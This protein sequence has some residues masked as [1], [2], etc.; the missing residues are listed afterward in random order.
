MKKTGL[1][2]LL[3]ALLVAQVFLSGCVSAF[4]TV[5]FSV[6][7]DD[8]PNVTNKD[9]KYF[10][11]RIDEQRIAS[12]DMGQT[13]PNLETVRE[14]LH[15]RHADW[16]SAEP[17]AVP[18]VVKCRTSISK[19]MNAFENISLALWYPIHLCSLGLVPIVIPA[20]KM[21]FETSFKTGPEATTEPFV[22]RGT[23]KLA[24]GNKLT[25]NESLFPESRGW[26]RYDPKER[27]G[28]VARTRFDIDE[29][30]KCDAFC[31]SVALAAQRL[32]PEERKA[33]RENNEAWWLDAKLGNKRNRPVTVVKNEAPAE[34]SMP[35]MRTKH[36]VILSQEWNAGT[37]VGKI[38]FVIDSGLEL[39]AAME[40]LT[41]E[42]LPEYCRTLGAVVSADD[43]SSTSS[44]VICQDTPVKVSES[45][46]ILRFL[47]ED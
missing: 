40:W 22:Y 36:P 21:D 45:S 1:Y 8:V 10:V 30:A 43:P 20:A 34:P 12:A 17:D 16:F 18:V 9:D 39:E 44:A 28:V 24:G 15:V 41:G 42:Y 32:T 47:V 33:L 6:S 31:A 13:P 26:H 27:G 38:E 29:R 19:G 23:S 35:Q 4:E 37:R 25:A 2:A 46:Y 5:R 11:V 14:M 3:G 7:P